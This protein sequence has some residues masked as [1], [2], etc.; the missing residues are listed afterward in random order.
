MAKLI[1]KYIIIF[2]KTQDKIHSYDYTLIIISV[3]S[4]TPIKWKM[5]LNTII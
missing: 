2:L 4:T 5:Y 1:K 3:Y